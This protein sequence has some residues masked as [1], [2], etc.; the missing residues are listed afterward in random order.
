LRGASLASTETAIVGGG[1]FGAGLFFCAAVGNT[2]AQSTISDN[3]V[4]RDG[5][6]ME[7]LEETEQSTT[8]QKDKRL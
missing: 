1:D 8:Q 5:E 7:L 6:S 3:Q 2:A 4:R